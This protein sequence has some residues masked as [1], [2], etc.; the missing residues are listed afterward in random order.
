MIPRL[1]V[2]LLEHFTSYLAV[3]FIQDSSGCHYLAV[4]Y[5]Q[6]INKWRN[7]SCNGVLPPGSMGLPI[8]G[9]TLELIVPSCSLYI[10]PF[11]KQKNS[12]VWTDFSNKHPRTTC[13]SVC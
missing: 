12:K 3:S 9:E 5:T 13:S 1:E 8:I 11:I 4:F 7:P 6:W 2:E 10:H